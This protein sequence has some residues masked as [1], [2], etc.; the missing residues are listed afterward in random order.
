MLTEVKE[1]SNVGLIN[2]CFV[3]SNNIPGY[4]FLVT[5]LLTLIR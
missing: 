3:S 1:R 5:I 2:A 4:L